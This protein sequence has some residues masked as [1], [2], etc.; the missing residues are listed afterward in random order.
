MDV[1][2]LQQLF[3]ILLGSG[4][5]LLAIEIFVPGGILGVLGAMAL[6]GAITT[7]FWA[8]PS[9]GPVIA[10]GI[11]ILTALVLVVWIRVFPRTSL[12]KAMTVTGDL[13]NAK[14]AQP[15]I[16]ALTGKTGETVTDLRPGGYAMIDGKRMDVV[17]DGRMLD[18]GRQIQVVEVRGN[19]IVVKEVTDV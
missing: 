16:E 15:G 5:V 8:F 2:V 17:T 12:G 9:A 11:I 13:A 7:G 14:A 3:F 1:N 4:L 6:V 19:R 18:R 10:A